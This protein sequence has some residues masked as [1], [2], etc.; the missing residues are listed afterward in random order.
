[1]FLNTEWEAAYLATECAR[2]LVHLKTF[3]AVQTEKEESLR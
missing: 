2:E 1:M 3:E